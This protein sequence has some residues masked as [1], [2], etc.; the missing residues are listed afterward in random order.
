VSSPDGKYI[1]YHSNVSGSWNIWRADSDG[2]NPVQ[3]THGPR[4]SNWPH[5]TPDSKFVVFHQTDP[6]GQLNLW[7]VPIAGGTPIQLTTSMTTHPAVSPKDGK[8]VAWYSESVDHP[9]WKLAVFAPSGGKPLQVFTPSVAISA[10][11]QLGWSPGAEAIT[12]LGQE[13]G[14]WNVFNQPLDGR[15]AKR[16]TSFVSGQIYSFDWSKDGRLAFSHG[17]S[18]TDVVIVRDKRRNS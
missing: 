15:P 18:T 12:C 3:I 11:S 5:F 2:S 16:L 13:N 17:V 9:Q 1:A 8:I 10:D 6:G 14:V 7:K 4:D